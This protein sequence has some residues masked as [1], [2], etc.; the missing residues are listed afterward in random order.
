MKIFK[1]EKHE[2]LIRLLASAKQD[3]KFNQSEIKTRLL[4]QL[5]QTPQLS[6]NPTVRISSLLIFRSGFFFAGLI[7]VASGTFAAASHSGPG[8]KLFGVNKFRQELLLKLPLSPE[9]QAKAQAHLVEERL[10][11]LDELPSQV[12]EVKLRQEHKKLEVI[13]ETE[14]SLNQAIDTIRRN[15]EA[16]EKKGNTKAASKLQ[17]VLT[18]IGDMAQKR[19]ET[20]KRIEED[21]KN[22]ARRE[23]LE[24]RLKDLRSAR[25][26]AIEEGRRREKIIDI[27]I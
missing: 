1:S 6:A 22:D 14:K 7:L 19:E 16:L 18:T 13:K 26:K 5:P 27:E 11:S 8:D 10:K 24:G 4:A 23:L 20:I 3:F 17:D 12:S 2:K 25:Q 21:S 15:Q 9:G